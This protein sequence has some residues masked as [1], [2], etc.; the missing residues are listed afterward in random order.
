MFWGTW[1]AP[2]RVRSRTG[3]A[4]PGGSRGADSVTKD[5][6]F[7]R[8]PSRQT[9]PSSRPLSS[10]DPSY[11]VPIVFPCAAFG[12][13]DSTKYVRP[14]TWHRGSY[15]RGVTL[16]GFMSAT[17][18]SSCGRGWSARRDNDRLLERFLGVVA[19]SHRTL[20]FPARQ[21]IRPP[22]AKPTVLPMSIVALPV[23]PPRRGHHLA[24]RVLSHVTEFRAPSSTSPSTVSS[25]ATLVPF[26]DAPSGATVPRTRLQLDAGDR[27][28]RSVPRPARLRAVLRGS[29]GVLT[30]GR[31]AG[32]KSFRSFPPYWEPSRTWSALRRAS[33]TPRPLRASWEQHRGER[34]L[35][36]SGE[37]CGEL[38]LCAALTA[39]PTL[40]SQTTSHGRRRGR[41]P[42]LSPK[43]LR[44]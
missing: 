13:F 28:C 15:K 23:S 36:G 26:L 40:R 1:G 9:R 8:D 19:V 25:T 14:A 27:P 34:L 43:V 2:R 16:S 42:L 41:R 4:P 44:L 38:R 33:A 22:V 10:S 37:K 12:G 29:A 24:P 30:D 20:T 35:I 11:V 7:L 32:C 21:R 5:N 31:R 17:R 3:G 6:L 18:S 39:L